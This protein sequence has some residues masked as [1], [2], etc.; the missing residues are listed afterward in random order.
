[1]RDMDVLYRG[2]LKDAE[3]LGAEYTKDLLIRYNLSIEQHR[4]LKMHADEK[5]IDYLCT[6]WDLNSVQNLEKFGVPV[7]KVASADL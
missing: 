5:G 1:M 6:P 4:E 7:Y 3:D 2:D